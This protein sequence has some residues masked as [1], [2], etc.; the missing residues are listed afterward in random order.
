MFLQ[1]KVSTKA[2]GTY[3]A[4]V[5]LLIIVCVH[6]KREIVDLMESFIAYSAFIL[7]FCAM[8]KF[9]VFIVS[10]LVEAFPAKFARERFVVEVN[11]HVRVQSGTTVECFSAR[12]T[13]VRFI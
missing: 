11:A 7:F 3:S 1:I 9:M 13:L 5:W 4:R 2:F 6:V 12:G 10:F 8:C